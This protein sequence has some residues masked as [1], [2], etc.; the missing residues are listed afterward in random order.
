MSDK[1][2]DFD[3]GAVV[4]SLTLLF[5]YHTRL[6]ITNPKCFGKKTPFGV[7]LENASIWIRKHKEMSDSPTVLLAIHTLRNTTMVGIFIGGNAIT[8]AFNMINDYKNVEGM[9]MKVRSIIISAL[10]FASFLAWANVIR[11]CS[12]MGYMLGTMQYAENLR[13]EAIAQELAE[14]E[15]A[16]EK[17]VSLT[18]DG[19]NFVRSAGA[20]SHTPTL[21]PTTTHGKRRRF[22]FKS[23][24]ED[25]L[26]SSEDNL[27]KRKFI[28]SRIPDAY[29]ESK[30]MLQ[31]QMVYFS[32]GMRLIFVSVPFAF[33]SAGPEALI[34]AT[35]MLLLFLIT[36]DYARAVPNS[37]HYTAPTTSGADGADSQPADQR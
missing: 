12:S 22:S 11:L 16:E 1:L 6:Y 36:F 17:K 2:S 29:A 19:E 31:L 23:K 20:A 8:I 25:S 3:V 30:R 15:A 13:K 21:T 10:M 7:N 32:L 27:A 24:F 26:V 37:L 4:I 28:I 18:S 14:F 35:G 33:Y 9:Q 34:I 5:L